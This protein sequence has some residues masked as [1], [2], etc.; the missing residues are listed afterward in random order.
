MAFGMKWGSAIDE[1]EH[2]NI[3]S[4]KRLFYSVRFKVTAS[5]LLTFKGTWI[6]FSNLS[7]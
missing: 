6:L 3:I 4:N 7:Y 2:K 5:R 1:I